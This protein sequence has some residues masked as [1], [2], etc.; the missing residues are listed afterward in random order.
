ME[1]PARNKRRARAQ[2]RLTRKQGWCKSNAYFYRSVQREF[3][4]ERM[5]LRDYLRGDALMRRFFDVF[6]FEDVPAADRRADDLYLGEV[7]RC[8]VFIGLFGNEYFILN[9]WEPVSAT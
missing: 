9:A 1:T 5:A 3:A 7:E 4:E 2:A 8:D 6:L